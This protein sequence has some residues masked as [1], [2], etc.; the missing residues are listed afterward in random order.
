MPVPIA[1]GMPMPIPVS[2]TMKMPQV[3]Q[4]P[5]PLGGIHAEYLAKTIPIVN[6][7]VEQNP[8]YK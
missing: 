1:S 7:I 2:G 3:S 5:A 8:N 4:Q 6:A